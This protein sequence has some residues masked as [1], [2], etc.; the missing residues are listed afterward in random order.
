MRYHIGEKW[1][2]TEWRINLDKRNGEI[3]DKLK[4]GETEE[5]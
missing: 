4:G 1:L 3:F 5:V 2:E